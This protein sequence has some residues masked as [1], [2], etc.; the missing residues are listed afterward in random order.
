MRLGSGQDDEFV[1]G[2][3]GHSPCADR[4]LV[5]SA[6]NY[7]RPMAS[8]CS[9]RACTATRRRSRRSGVTGKR[10]AFL[11]TSLAA[12]YAKAIA[13]DYRLPTTN[14]DGQAVMHHV[15]N[16]E[17]SPQAAYRANVDQL[18]SRADAYQCRKTLHCKPATTSNSIGNRYLE[19][20]TNLAYYAVDISLGHH[21]LRATQNYYSEQR[22]RRI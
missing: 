20:R 8:R 10:P 1:G 13:V 14:K 16:A 21:A 11:P 7:W 5:A 19:P 15:R 22:L 2:G 18:Y 9:S 12:G 6:L 17:G 4:S 3:T